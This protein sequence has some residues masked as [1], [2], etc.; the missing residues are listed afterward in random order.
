MPDGGRHEAV[1]RRDRVRSPGGDIGTGRREEGPAGLQLRSALVVAD[2]ADDRADG[3]GADGEGLRRA[4]RSG[5]APGRGGENAEGRAPDEHRPPDPLL[6][7]DP[8]HRLIP[9][10]RKLVLEEGVDLE[11]ELGGRRGRLLAPSLAPRLDERAVRASSRCAGGEDEGGEEERDSGAA[12][13]GGSSSSI[14]FAV[15]S[16]GCVRS[17]PVTR[18][19]SL[20]DVVKHYGE[21]KAVDGVSFEVSAGRITGLLGRNG[22]GKTTTLRMI[23]GVLHPDRGRVELF[24]AEVETARDRLGYLPEERGLYRKMRVLDHLL[25]LAEIKGR[26]PA[27]MRPA[28]ERWLARF[29]LQEK[30]NAKVEELSKGNQQKVQLAGALLFDPE[31]VVLDEPG[32]GLDPVN[33]VLVRRLLRELAAEGKAILLST[34]QMGEAEKLCDEIVLI[35]AGKVIRSGPLPEVKASG[36]RDAVHLE[37]AGDGAFLAEHPAVASARVDTNRAELQL[38]PG[39]DAQEVLAAAAARLRVLRFEVVA[40]SLEEVFLEAVGETAPPEVAA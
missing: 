20:H 3:A 10:E 28:A 26:S 1:T 16:S 23:T 13:H 18:V 6:P 12:D 30:R 21:V 40:P 19:L 8:A 2:A 33:V 17:R 27:A 11:P 38:A 37:F 29:E 31:L 24:G 5:N 22:A 7:L 36:G 15:R 14:R 4:S 32:S 9:Q 35:H 25:F 39:G 34:H